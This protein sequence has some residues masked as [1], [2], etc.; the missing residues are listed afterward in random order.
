[1]KRGTNVA[2]ET[3][4]TEAID[5]SLGLGWTLGVA[6]RSLG[7]MLRLH[8]P[9]Q[10]GM[11]IEIVL[12]ARGPIVR[13]SAA[14]LEIESAD[15]IVAKCNR[16]TVEAR[17]AIVMSAR[18]IEHHASERARLEAEEIAIEARS[19]DVRV[20]ANDDVQLL[21]EQVLLNCERQPVLPTWLPLPSAAPA[22]LPP[23]DTVGAPE[24]FESLDPKQR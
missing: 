23:Q 7:A 2:G 13:A 5:V 18:E 12:S 14:T 20:R 8:H 3:A 6:P 4:S 10:A 15:E 21:G 24:L 22:T 9:G 11:A 16:F 19:G 17:D 1:M